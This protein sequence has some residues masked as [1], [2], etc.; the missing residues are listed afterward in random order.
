M[1]GRPVTVLGAVSVMCQCRHN[2]SRCSVYVACG[3][4][5]VAE[6]QRLSALYV[7]QMLQRSDDLG[8]DA[9]W[10]NHHVSLPGWLRNAYCELEHVEP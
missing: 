4:T 7:H 1:S 9:L 8:E 10:K 3:E 5:A 6:A 2:A